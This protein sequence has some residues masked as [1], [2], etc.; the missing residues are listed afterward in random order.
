MTI[1]FTKLSHGRFDL[2]SRG[3]LTYLPGGEEG[4]YGV[5]C[6]SYNGLNVNGEGLPERG[7]GISP[8]EVNERDVKKCK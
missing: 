6:T 4:V 1:A 3:G 7:I 8:V 5:G 2:S